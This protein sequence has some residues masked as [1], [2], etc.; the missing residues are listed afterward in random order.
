M[1]STAAWYSLNRVFCFGSSLAQKGKISVK[2]FPKETLSPDTFPKGLKLW[3]THSWFLLICFSFI[4]FLALLNVSKMHAIEKYILEDTKGQNSWLFPLLAVS[5]LFT[6]LAFPGLKRA[7]H[8]SFLSTLELHP[9]TG[10]V[11]PV[12]CYYSPFWENEEDDIKRMIL[13]SLTICLVLCFSLSLCY[14]ECLK[15]QYSTAVWIMWQVSKG[16]TFIVCLWR[17]LFILFPSSMNPWTW[18]CPWR[19]YLGSRLYLMTLYETLIVFLLGIFTYP[20][21]RPQQWQYH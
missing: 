18:T 11:P 5:L 1:L 14:E 13:S 10:S 16:A 8:D 12:P 21:H 6:A 15:S 7:L 2:C 19:D 9:E 20:Y 17:L 3:F 4:S